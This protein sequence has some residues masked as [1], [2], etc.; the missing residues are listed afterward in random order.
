MIRAARQGGS[1]D[2]QFAE[3][4]RVRRLGVEAPD[5]PGVPAPEVRL[6]SLFPN[7]T[8]PPG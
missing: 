6:P 3:P 1:L 7:P 2:A 4:W 8:A 5:S